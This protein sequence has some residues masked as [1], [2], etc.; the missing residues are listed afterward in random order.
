[1]VSSFN[2]FEIAAA[3]VVVVSV[4]SFINVR[5]LKLQPTIALMGMGAVASVLFVLADMATPETHSIRELEDFLGKVDFRQTFL[6]G[7]L[8]FLLFAGAF[9]LEYRKVKQVRWPIMVLSTLGV[10]ASTAIVGGG[11]YFATH[12]VGTDVPLLWCFVFGALISSTDPVAVLAIM[13]AAR[14]PEN[15]E[16]TVA[17]ES[18]FNDG[19][20]IAVF[21]VLV[22]AASGGGEVSAAEAGKLFVVEGGGGLALGLGIGA[23]GFLAMRAIDDYR[24][25]LMISIAVAMGGYACAARVGVSAPIA[26]ATA[27]LLLGNHGVAHA[28]S[29]TVRD[30]LLK[31]WEVLD[32]MLN[33]ILFLL[34]GLFSIILAHDY[35]LFLVGVAAVPVVLA[36]RAISVAAPLPLWRRQLPFRSAFPALVWGGLRGGVSIALVLSLPEGRIRDVIMGATYVV[37]LFS[38]LV[39]GSTLPM[40]LRRQDKLSRAPPQVPAEAPSA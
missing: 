31:F 27:G 19:V 9:H 32:E 4:F 16:A 15:I 12:W 1:M 23:L 11:F 10:I 8:S 29:E 2:G 34:M 30:Y 17:G 25:E 14:A 33:S 40:L 22:A 3:L 24:V 6:N 18:L 37:I 21:T 35:R 38:V 36:A 5:F 26:V 20:A 39:Q 13:K 7:M 28:M